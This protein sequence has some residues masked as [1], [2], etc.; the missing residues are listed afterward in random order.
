MENKILYPKFPRQVDFP[1]PDIDTSEEEEGIPD[2]NPDYHPGQDLERPIRSQTPAEILRSFKY[3]IMMHSGLV[4]FSEWMKKNFALI[5]RN[6]KIF[7]P[8]SFKD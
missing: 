4:I 7:E 2:A 1:D 8:S 6:G 3:G 5:S